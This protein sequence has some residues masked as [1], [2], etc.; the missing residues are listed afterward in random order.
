MFT[1]LRGST[2]VEMLEEFSVQAHLLAKKF[3]R[4]C[5]APAVEAQ[6]LENFQ[7]ATAA[8]VTNSIIYKAQSQKY[9]VL[10][11]ENQVRQS[12]SVT[13]RNWLRLVLAS[14]G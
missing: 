2:M 5:G 4:F 8:F 3:R 12:A 7:S 1:G 14:A 9:S 10:V 6:H 11:P 13:A